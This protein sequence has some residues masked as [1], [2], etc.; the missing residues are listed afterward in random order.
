MVSSDL[1]DIHWILE[2]ALKFAQRE[3]KRGNKY[4]GIIMDPPAFWIRSKQRALE[5][6][7]INLKNFSHLQKTWLN[8]L[9]LLSPILIHQGLSKKRSWRLPEVYF[10]R[11][12]LS[13]INCVSAQKTGK[14]IEYGELTRIFN[15]ICLNII[16]TD[17][18]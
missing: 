3:V 5:K 8:L 7:K 12:T 15:L 10:M 11:Q 17:C 13:A 18:K 6:L 4:K 2:D 16:W 14:I 9:V 1:S